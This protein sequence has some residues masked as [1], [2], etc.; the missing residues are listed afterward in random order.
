MALLSG[1]GWLPLKVI[2]PS[3]KSIT[4]KRNAKLADV[5]QCVGLDSFSSPMVASNPKLS[6]QQTV[7]LPTASSV[8]C[9]E[10][11]SL[12]TD[13]SSLPDHPLPKKP[14]GQTDQLQCCMKWDCLK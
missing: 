4:L 10:E 5:Y 8:C 11:Q 3:A 9:H 6:M 7:Q 2:N 12:T 13:V 1:D 14:S